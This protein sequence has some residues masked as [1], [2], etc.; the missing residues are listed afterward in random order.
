M[1][2]NT[3][4]EF[5]IEELVK[6]IIEEPDNL[7]NYTKLSNVYLMHKDYD[8]ALDILKKILNIF[9]DNY[10]ALINTGGILFFK[11]R[12]DEAVNYYTRALEL[13][14]RDYI[15]YLNLA[16]TTRPTRVLSL[17]LKVR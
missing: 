16:N 6:K 15:V 7:S 12:F 8:N 17:R 2:E 4:K 1:D 9:P 10:D 11:E 5:H 3:F 14:D 13:N